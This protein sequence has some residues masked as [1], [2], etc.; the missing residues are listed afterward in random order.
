MFA[1]ISYLIRK[2]YIIS[3]NRLYVQFKINLKLFPS[4]NVPFIDLHLLNI[5]VWIWW[6]QKLKQ[7]Q[8]QV[9]WNKFNICKKLNC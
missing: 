7:A 8:L 1:Q 2:I 6:P 5:F 9:S 4:E 3:L